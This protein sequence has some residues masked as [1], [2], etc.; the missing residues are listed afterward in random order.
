MVAILVDVTRCVG[1]ERCVDACRRIATG[2]GT[3]DL[4]QVGETLSASQRCAIEPV[5]ANRWAR[6]SCLHCLEPACV[7]ACLV[8]GLTKIPEGPVIYDPAK[9]IGCRYCMLACPYHVPRYEW[10]R[11][12]PLVTKCDMCRERLDRGRLPAC[13]EACPHDALRFGDRRDL[14]AA[15][16]ATIDREPDRYLPR[17]WGEHEWGG[18]SV[19]YLSDVDLAGLGFPEAARP[20]IPTLTDPLIG[21]TPFLGT[22]VFV[23]LWALGAII[24]R[25]NA[26]MASE[27]RAGHPDGVNQQR[28]VD[29]PEGPD[30]EHDGR[31]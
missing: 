31:A 23:G 7:A 27:G 17:V 3:V 2:A 9:C 1:C 6:K 21:E 12:L 10:D 29:D 30:E 13:V 5:A 26:V 18:T 8:G 15:A 22:G 24:A 19:L 20:P 4:S 28:G 16:H 25:R 11:R 14:L